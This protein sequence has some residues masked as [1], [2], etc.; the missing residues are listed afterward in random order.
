MFNYLHFLSSLFL[1][2]NVCVYWLFWGR[3]ATLHSSFNAVVNSLT[4][5][6]LNRQLNSWILNLNPIDK[7]TDNIKLSIYSL[8]FQSDAFESKASIWSSSDFRINCSLWCLMLENQ[9]WGWIEE[10]ARNEE[11]IYVF[12]TQWIFL[13]FWWVWFFSRVSRHATV[14]AFALALTF[15]VGFEWKWAQQWVSMT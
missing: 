7:R 6:E 14:F 12:G 13:D 5:S 1:L 4:F 2:Q 10:W 11:N 8:H 15:T 9:L 3:H